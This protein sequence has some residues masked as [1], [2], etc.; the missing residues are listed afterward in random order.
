MSILVDETF[1]RTVPAG[2]RERVLEKLRDFV[3]AWQESGYDVHKLGNGY[4]IYKIKST[5]DIYKFRMNDGDRILF[6]FLSKQGRWG[7]TKGFR[8]DGMAEDNLLILRYCEHDRAVLEA[9]RMQL[10]LH[11]TSLALAEASPAVA[12]M[13]ENLFDQYAAAIYQDYQYMP[14]RSIVQIITADRLGEL[15]KLRQEETYYYLSDAQYE[16]LQK[17]LPVFLFGCA[18]SGKTT[19]NVRKLYAMTQMPQ[20]NGRKASIGYFTYSEQLEA[21]VKECTTYF[22][23]QEG[24]AASLEQIEFW[25][26][27]RFLQDK[28]Q[29]GWSLHYRRFAKWYQRLGRWK[30]DPFAVWREIRGIIKGMIGLDWGFDT[31]GALSK[32]QLSYKEYVLL[33]DQYS[34]F[35]R[36]ERGNLYKIAQLYQRWL[37]KNAEADDNDLTNAL[38]EKVQ[39]GEM[40]KY[41]Y[42]V[43]DEIQDLTE[44]EIFLLYRLVKNPYHIFWSGDSNQTVNATYFAPHRLTSLLL[45]DGRSMRADGKAILTLNYRCAPPIVD[46]ANAWVSLRKKALHRDKFDKKYD[47]AELPVQIEDAETAYPVL[48]RPTEEN[49][50]QLFWAVEQ[51]SYATILVNDEAGKEKL[52]QRGIE[53]VFT[54]SEIKGIEKEYIVCYN[55]I[56]DHVGCWKKIFKGEIPTE[57]LYR[58]RYLF[59]AFYV[60]ITR[61]RHFLCFVEDHA[62]DIYETLTP[63][64]DYVDCYGERALHL[65]AASG[66]GDFQKEGARLERNHAYAQAIAAYQRAGNDD[67]VLRCQSLLWQ[68]QGEFKKAADGFYS[69]RDYENALRCYRRQNDIAG[70]VQS[71]ILLRRP[72]REILDACQGDNK[73]ISTIIFGQQDEALAYLYWKSYREYL[74]PGWHQAITGILPDI[75]HS[76]AIIEKT[77]R[78]GERDYVK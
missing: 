27:C 65:R 25:S 54:I 23:Q 22:F 69:L 59:N 57:C 72:Y 78:Q 9:R 73:R 77:L 62:G 37:D 28:N 31:P 66:R 63:Y 16:I 43:I 60:G 49:K 6:T 8:M 75:Q 55:L 74:E 64:L 42:V 4:S 41:D 20:E 32:R 13:E 39:R 68:E 3:R 47:Y 36:T 45:K 67:A 61:A 53:N 33:G 48:L 15:G 14:D 71:Q 51:R 7:S 2:K 24:Q 58:Y 70:M 38:L 34:V 46:L 19:I 35:G 1:L 50:Q 29:Q 18:G 17:P 10:V 26:V 11:P 52:R 12:D 56:S 44:R 76:W 30:Y 21:E 5:E 40:P